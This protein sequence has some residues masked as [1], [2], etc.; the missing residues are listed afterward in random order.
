MSNRK[1][2]P[3]TPLEE[4]TLGQVLAKQAKALGSKPMM[5]ATTGESVTYRELDEISNRI[6]HGLAG[7]GI[8]AQEPVLAMLPATL[9]RLLATRPLL[10]VPPLLPAVLPAPRLPADGRPPRSFSM[11]FCWLCVF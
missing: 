11:L 6:A 3:Q 8:E 7:L 1:E 9:R 4:R 10:A 2:I 5:I